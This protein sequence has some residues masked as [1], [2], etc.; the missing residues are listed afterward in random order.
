MHPFGIASRQARTYTS[1]LVSSIRMFRDQ[2]LRF[3]AERLLLLGLSPGLPRM[4]LQIS[5]TLL[6]TGRSFPQLARLPCLRNIGS[7]D[8]LLGMPDFDDVHGPH[9]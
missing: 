7:E 9:T 6:E 3:V 8:I 2:V 1:L 5:D 4:K